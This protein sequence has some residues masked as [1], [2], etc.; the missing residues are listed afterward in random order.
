MLGTVLLSL[1]LYADMFPSLDLD[2]SGLSSL[3]KM[4]Q[5]I[6][7]MV[8]M[9]KKLDDLPVR[10]K[11]ANVS[12]HKSDTKSLR[13]YLNQGTKALEKRYPWLYGVMENLLMNKE[14]LEAYAADSAY[15]RKLGD[16]N[17]D[18]IDEIYLHSQSRCGASICNYRVYQIDV[19]HKMLREILD[20]YSG[21]PKSVLK[22]RYNGWNVLRLQK[23]WGAADCRVNIYRYDRITDFYQITESYEKVSGNEKID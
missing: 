15:F 11:D 6:N 23:G 1:A 18:G 13:P 19:K 22:E 3:S 12:K 21:D 8:E 16:L 9:E 2:F 17:G 10:F 20:A 5:Q 7:G 14:N 4:G